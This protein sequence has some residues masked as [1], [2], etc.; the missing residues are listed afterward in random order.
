MNYA[1]HNR[2]NRILGI[3]SL[4]LTR[5]PGGVMIEYAASDNGFILDNADV[6]TVAAELLKAAGHE[7]VIVPKAYEEVVDKGNG[8]IEC[9]GGPEIAFG[10]MSQN[11]NWLY[12]RA[13]NYVAL[14]QHIESA[15]REAAEKA[16]AEAAEKKLQERRDAVAAELD[17][18]ADYDEFHPTSPFRKAIDRII[19]L[20]DAAK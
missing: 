17:G 20:E 9:G 5:G 11:P 8:L 18:G 4:G 12:N 16:E 2:H 15:A 7:S 3:T 6:P 13:A 19:E 10:E 1:H 14:A